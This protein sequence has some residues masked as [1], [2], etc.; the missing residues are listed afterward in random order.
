MRLQLTPTTPFP[1][2]N[3]LKLVAISPFGRIVGSYVVFIVAIEGWIS[4]G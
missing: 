1:A 3:A 2:T 4:E